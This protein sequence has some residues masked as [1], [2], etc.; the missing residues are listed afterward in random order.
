MKLTPNMTQRLAMVK[1][2]INL[3]FNTWLGIFQQNE[4]LLRCEDAVH[5]IQLVW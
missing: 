2:V 5:L 4:R 3:G 1:T